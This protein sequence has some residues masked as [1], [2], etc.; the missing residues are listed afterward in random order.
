MTASISQYCRMHFSR[1]LLRLQE[2][3]IARRF[4]KYAKYTKSNKSLKSVLEVNIA[5]W[6]LR[7]SL[8]DLKANLL[9]HVSL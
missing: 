7:R 9:R 4:E 8:L 5:G 2:V 3:N 6:L 1:V